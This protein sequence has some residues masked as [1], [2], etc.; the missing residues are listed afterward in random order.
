VTVRKGKDANAAA[1]DPME[2]V[3]QLLAMIAVRGLENQEAARRLLAIGFDSP[4]IGAIL[5]VGSNFANVAK[6]RAPKRGKD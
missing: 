2:R 1:H 4:Q 6:S 5:G 3:S